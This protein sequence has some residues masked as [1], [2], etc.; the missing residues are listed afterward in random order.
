MSQGS[1]EQAERAALSILDDKQMHALDLTIRTVPNPHQQTASGYP[2]LIP[3]ALAFV[4]HPWSIPDAAAPVA[5]GSSTLHPAPNSGMD[6]SGAPARNSAPTHSWL[7]V[8]VDITTGVLGQPIPCWTGPLPQHLSVASVHDDDTATVTPHTTTQVAAHA[9]VRENREAVPT[10]ATF[11][12]GVPTMQAMYSPEFEVSSGSASTGKSAIRSTS[13]NNNRDGTD[14][15]CT[16]R[17]QAV[18]SA[19]SGSIVEAIANSPDPNDHVASQGDGLLP[20]NYDS[21]DDGWVNV[22]E[23]RLIH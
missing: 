10:P 14:P 19:A 15:V 7:F 12:S 20:V 1:A 11:A 6:L 18:T 16:D 23:L 21:D 4:C 13:I 2:G 8:P 5:K 9:R 17:Q 22:S 3:A